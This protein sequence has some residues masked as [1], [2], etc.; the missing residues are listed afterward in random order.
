MKTPL[1]PKSRDPLVSVLAAKLRLKRHKVER[2]RGT[3]R[4]LES[5]CERLEAEL[6]KRC[7]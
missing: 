3:L 1:H 6:R 4:H 5:E 2:L 7:T